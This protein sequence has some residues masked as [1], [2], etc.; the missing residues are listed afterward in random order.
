MKERR[1]FGFGPLLVVHGDTDS[2]RIIEMALGIWE[3]CLKDE[4]KLELNKA[5]AA[6]T[7]IRARSRT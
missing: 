7:A 4:F 1:C 3:R 5:Q 6:G 2:C